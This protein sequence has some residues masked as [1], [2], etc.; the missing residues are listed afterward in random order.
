M[1][2][3]QPHTPPA[4][5]WLAPYAARLEQL[6][7]TVERWKREPRGAV[8]AHP[9]A[10]I[11]LAGAW[12]RGEW[13]VELKRRITAAALAPLL[14]Q[15]KTPQ[16]GDRP[17]LLLTELI[18]PPIAEEL[19]AHAIQ[20]VDAAG[21]AFLEQRG[22]LV[23]VVGRKPATPVRPGRRDLHTAGL[24]LLFVLLQGRRT[25]WTQRA[26]AEDAGIALG[27]VGRI[28]N[29]FERRNWIRRTAVDAIE[30]VDPAEMLKRWD[31]G[32][33][34]TLRPKLLLQTCR[35]RP[36][37]ELGELR[38][39][40]TAAQLDA[41]VRI[42]G[43]FGAALLT[44]HLRPVAATLHL[45]GIDD[46]EIMRRLELVPARDGDVALLQDIGGHVVTAP[47]RANVA[48]P[49]L[50]HAEL[51]V[52]HDDRLREVAELVRTEHIETRWR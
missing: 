2:K 26:L 29:E 41:H 5:E 14:H 28:L 34:E 33:A 40:I 1:A 36:R 17:V 4:P 46:K 12:G 7:V 25:D 8:P 21:N 18:T 11:Q 27:G 24:R 52:R 49:L 51:L 19:R 30:L 13:W 43:E 31:E 16:T 42:G 9:D 22:L 15:L 3:T 32:F 35:R 39:Q 37:T 47:A 6:G 20:F 23:W 50:V 10:R 45:T 48:D 44:D 38:T